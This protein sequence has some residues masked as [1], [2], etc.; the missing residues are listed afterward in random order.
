MN[1]APFTSLSSLLEPI[2]T[3]LTISAI[4]EEGAK[5][6][7][8]SLESQVEKV[9]LSDKEEFVGIVETL[10]HVLDSYPS[11]IQ[12]TDK[13]FEKFKEYANAAEVPEGEEEDIEY[14]YDVMDVM[15]TVAHFVFSY[16][17]SNNS[18]SVDEELLSSLVQMMP[19]APGVENVPALIECLA[20]LLEDTDRFESIAVESLKMFTELLLM[21]KSELDEF[22]IDNDVSKLMKDTLKNAIKS[23]PA[24]QKLISKDFQNSRAKVNRF[25]ALIR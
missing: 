2:A 10:R 25:N 15:P 8:A 4:K 11:S 3:G 24:L 12:N 17:S 20:S 23:K 18:A 1:N 5:M 19:F 16:Y 13:F 6:V 14:H 21:K 7:A 22:G 9:T